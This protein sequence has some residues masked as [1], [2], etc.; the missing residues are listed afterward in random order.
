[1][2]Y[3]VN[4]RIQKQLKKNPAL[5]KPFEAVCEKI[6]AMTEEQIRV[7]PGLDPHP[8]DFK[9][10]YWS[11]KMSR[12]QRVVFAFSEGKVYLYDIPESHEKA[13]RQGSEAAQLTE[14]VLAELERQSVI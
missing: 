8:L 2:E 6:K 1:M 3:E 10:P 7:S 5:R 13:Y 4:D 11:L 14:M 9:P 12:G